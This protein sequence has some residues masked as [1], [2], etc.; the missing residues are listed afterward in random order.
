MK[1]RNTKRKIIVYLL[2]F[3]IIFILITPILYLMIFESL[4]K[5]AKVIGT[6]KSSMVTMEILKNVNEES[7]QYKKINILT[8]NDLHGSI[9]ESGINIG[10]P[11]LGAEVKRIKKEEK[12]TILVGGGDLYQGSAISNLLYGKPVSEVLK[13]MGMKYT[14]VGNHEFDWGLDKIKKWSESIE[15]LGSNIIDKNT[16]EVV[17]WA[18]PYVI[19]EF[20]G[21]KVG[22]IGITTP[23]STYKTKTENIKDLEF[24]DPAVAASEWAKYLKIEKAV[25][26][27][28]VLSH[29]GGRQGTD[30]IITGEL[31][32]LAQKATG[33]DGIV[34]AHS[35]TYIA[36]F[37]NDIPIVQAGSNGRAL[38]KLEI[39]IRPDGNLD[40]KPSYDKLYKRINNLKEDE[41]IKN[42]VNKYEEELNPI[43]KEKVAFIDKDLTHKRT[44]NG[45]TM[46]GQF[47]TKSMV[48]LS[49]SQIGLINSGGMRRPL[50]KGIITV[51]DMWD[52]MPFDN[53]LVTMRLK[54][55]DL[56]RVM[57]H[58]IINENIGGI[59]FYGLNIYYDSTKD[60]GN[61][62]SSMKL[63]DGTEIEMDKYYTVVTNDFMYY[64]GDNYDFTGAID[65]KDTGRAVRDVL[66]EKF[67]EIGEIT[68][69]YKENSIINKKDERAW[70]QFLN[71][72]YRYKLNFNLYEVL[73][74]AKIAI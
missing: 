20:D 7:E 72:N 74:S 21:V 62:I 14:V 48:E 23:E 19:E 10:A 16:K 3:F 53:N 27:V 18:K 40:I 28:I 41:K 70:N 36:G 29:L 69:E 51:G 25:D 60:Y 4:E 31:E 73:S 66:I 2:I 55:T 59:Q 11:K 61:R 15:F 35:H 26:I 17:Q 64:K 58:G 38:G 9:I 42:I 68:F 34:G 71:L 37:V 52:I 49:G 43:L 67:K 13:E 45:V 65:F 32:D 22:F 54:G 1:N 30:G 8:I 46:L 57:E 5:E 39:I 63:L 47:I 50:N 6:R 56:K 12:N 24:K 44:I 33:I